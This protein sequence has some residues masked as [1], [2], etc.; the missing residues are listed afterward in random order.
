MWDGLKKLNCKLSFEPE[1]SYEETLSS[2]K[3]LMKLAQK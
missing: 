3:D 1:E 2:M